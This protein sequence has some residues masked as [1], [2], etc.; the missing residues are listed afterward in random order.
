MGWLGGTG[1]QAHFCTASATSGGPGWVLKPPSLPAEAP[2]LALIGRARYSGHKCIPSSSD[3]QQVNG[4]YR[5][6]SLQFNFLIPLIFIQDYIPRAQRS[7]QEILKYAITV[8]LN[9]LSTEEQSPS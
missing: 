6:E 8:K 3:K 7:S 2:R 1:N 4:G 5:K 9:S